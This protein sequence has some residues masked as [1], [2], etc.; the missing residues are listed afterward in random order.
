MF[1]IGALSKQTG[2]NIVTIRYY[3]QIGLLARPSRTA[4]GRRTYEAS[5]VRRLALIRHA[6]DL[7]FGTDAIRALL[8]LQNAPNLPCGEA[9]RIAREQLV[10]VEE[11]ISRLLT[12][13]A[14]LAGM[15]GACPNTRAADCRIIEGLEHPA[16][17]GLA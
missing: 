14:E 2:V 7:G 6:R 16:A 3:E 17:P 4:S 10:A 12:L 13:K 1:S 9:S 5:V 11:R 15:I 8:A